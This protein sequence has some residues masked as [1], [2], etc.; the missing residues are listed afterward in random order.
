MGCWDAA[1]TKIGIS[2][3][4][5]VFDLVNLVPYTRWGTKTSTDKEDSNTW[6][7]VSNCIR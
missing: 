7:T 5:T 2:S 3:I 1:K 4:N 6:N